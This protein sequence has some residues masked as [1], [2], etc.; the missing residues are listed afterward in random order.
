M[1]IDLAVSALVV[2]FGPNGGVTNEYGIGFGS[3]R[4]LAT[5]YYKR[6]PTLHKILKKRPNDKIKLYMCNAGTNGDDSFA[7]HLADITQRV[8]IAHDGI[9]EA[10]NFGRTRLLGE[11]GWV[12][13]IPRPEHAPYGGQ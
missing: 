3:R 11:G 10:D 5:E 9:V 1:R 8:V 13:F 6:S 4:L 2:A 7:Q 12:E